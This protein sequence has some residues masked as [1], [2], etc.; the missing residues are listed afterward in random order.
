MREHTNE[1]MNAFVP[2]AQGT[3]IENNVSRILAIVLEE[4]PQLLDCFLDIINK[5][6]ASLGEKLVSKPESHED[7]TIEIQQTASDIAEKFDGMRKAH[8][9]A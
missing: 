1:H 8:Q 5:N 2:Y 4:N 3:R 9:A 6:L 7:F